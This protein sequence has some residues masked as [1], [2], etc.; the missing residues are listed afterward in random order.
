MPNTKSAK[1][2]LRINLRRRARNKAIK[3]RTKTF[4]KRLRRAIEAGD[5]ETALKLYPRVMSEIDRA[6]KKGVFHDN[7]ASRYKSRLSR[8]LNALLKAQG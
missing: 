6:A 3:S 1:R 2:Q 5:K 8:K 7:K 4:M